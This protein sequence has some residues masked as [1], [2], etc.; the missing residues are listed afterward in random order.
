MGYEIRKT[1]TCVVTV[2][3]RGAG[4]T[5]N[6]VRSLESSTVAVS[7]VVVDNTPFDP[8][9]EGALS[10]CPDLP[11]IRAPANLGF[12][13]GCNLGIQWAME[14]TACEFMLILN[15]DAVIEP[16]AVR[17]MEEAMDAHPKAGIVTARVV[18]AEDTS[19]LLYGGGEVDWKRGGGRAPGVHGPSDA[20]LARQGR[21]VSFACG[22][23]MLI[24]RE[25]LRRCGD[26]DPRYFMYEEDLELSLRVMRNGWV[27]WYEPSALV[28][29]KGHGSLGSQREGTFI[30]AW[31]PRNPNLQFYAYHIFHNR[32]LT[33]RKYARGKNRIKFMVFFPPFIAI[34]VLRFVRHRRWKAIGAFYEGWRVYRKDVRAALQ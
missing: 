8:L 26:F 20:P 1:R 25:V 33:M 31:D 23:A 10:T 34:K 29:H 15:N 11:L 9:L 2:N 5:A 7:V 16:D 17:Y 22:C 32:L 4:D 3:F 27:I 21:Y 18:S 30:A 28:F 24:R 12:G 14:N 13:K 6:C 19:K